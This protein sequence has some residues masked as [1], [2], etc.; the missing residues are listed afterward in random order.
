MNGQAYAVIDD[1]AGKAVVYFH[2]S[3]EADARRFIRANFGKAPR[4]TLEGLVIRILWDWNDPIEFC[5]RQREDCTPVMVA[6]VLDW[7]PDLQVPRV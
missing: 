1:I 4:E 2:A 6:T 3:N 7:V 5:E